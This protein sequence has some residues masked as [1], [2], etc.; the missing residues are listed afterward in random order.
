MGV[1]GVGERG[2]PVAGA[3]EVQEEK[4]QLALI[5]YLLWARHNSNAFHSNCLI[6]T[7]VL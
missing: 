1:R 3:A 4:L 5:E 2:T 7:I 6:L